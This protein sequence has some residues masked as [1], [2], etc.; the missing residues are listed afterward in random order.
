[1]SSVIPFFRSFVV[2]TAVPPTL[3]LL[4]PIQT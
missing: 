1:M 2:A 3:Y 4:S